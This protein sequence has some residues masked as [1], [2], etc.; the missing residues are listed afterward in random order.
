VT[1]ELK[2]RLMETKSL[3]ALCILASGFP[4]ASV[5]EAG[6]GREL[7]DQ[8]KAI[9]DAAISAHETE[10][11]RRQMVYFL[12]SVLPRHNIVVSDVVPK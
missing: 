5:V 11:L 4:M 3:A 6:R 10:G 12:G 8:W 9:Q 2:L 1:L 7:Y